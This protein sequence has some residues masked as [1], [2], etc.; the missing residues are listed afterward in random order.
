MRQ[1]RPAVACK[2]EMLTGTANCMATAEHVQS[3][4]E[5]FKP[6]VAQRCCRSEQRTLSLYRFTAAATT[7]L[8]YSRMTTVQQRQVLPVGIER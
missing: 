5:V 1:Q 2:C 8:A 3:G 6:H 4:L 7:T